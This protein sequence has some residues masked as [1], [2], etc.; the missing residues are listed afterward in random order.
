MCEISV[1]S[2][3]SAI[4]P[5]EFQSSFGN[6]VIEPQTCPT[7]NRR[8]ILYEICRVTTEPPPCQLSRR[9]K[10]CHF[11]LSSLPRKCPAAGITA[12]SQNYHT[13]QLYYRESTIYIIIYV[14]TVFLYFN[15]KPARH[16]IYL[17]E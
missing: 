12:L 17:K 6:T 3:S 10:P 4:Q 16:L 8:I 11:V 14:K 2:S 5:A 7:S 1:V 15:C 9:S 13:K